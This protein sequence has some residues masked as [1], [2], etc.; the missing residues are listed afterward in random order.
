MRIAIAEEA[1]KL[2][3]SNK[4]IRADISDIAIKAAKEIEY[5]NVAHFYKA[6]IYD[7][8]QKMFY[9]FLLGDYKDIMKECQKND[10]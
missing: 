7:R 9:L 1:V 2:I 4:V 8:N 3:D 6:A 10:S 5:E